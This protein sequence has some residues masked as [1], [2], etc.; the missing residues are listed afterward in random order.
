MSTVQSRKE[1]FWVAGQR[2]KV[3]NIFAWNMIQVGLTFSLSFSKCVSQCGPVLE[4][5]NNFFLWPGF[6]PDLACRLTKI[7]A[8][9]CLKGKHSSVSE[10]VSS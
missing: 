9:L 7:L 2:Q 3:M 1:T 4:I 5:R 6:L 10:L 8:M